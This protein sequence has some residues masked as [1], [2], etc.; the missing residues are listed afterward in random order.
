MCA[1]PE[2]QRAVLAKQ[3]PDFDA[4]NYGYS[5]LSELAEA[6]GLLDVERIGDHP[7]V[8]M[9]KLKLASANG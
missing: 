3:A 8:V 1:Q 2:R 5:R 9:V 4:R 6:S 7:K